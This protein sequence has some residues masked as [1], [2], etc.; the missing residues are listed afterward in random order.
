[1]NDTQIRTCGNTKGKL[2]NVGINE[3]RAKTNARQRNATAQSN[4][5]DAATRLSEIAIPKSSA[6]KTAQSHFV[7]DSFAAVDLTRTRI[8]PTIA[9]IMRLS[10]WAAPAK[11]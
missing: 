2:K 9:R 1:P 6:T 5:S 11:L 8:P 4:R 7:S 3:I 10:K